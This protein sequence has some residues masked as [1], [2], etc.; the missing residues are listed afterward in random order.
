MLLRFGGG[1]CG[2]GAAASVAVDTAVFVDVVVVVGLV[3][4][5]AMVVVLMILALAAVIFSVRTIK[6]FETKYMSTRTGMTR[7]TTRETAI[8]ASKQNVLTRS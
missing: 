6:N 3:A 1:G 8:L 5:L 4:V 7:S 2:G